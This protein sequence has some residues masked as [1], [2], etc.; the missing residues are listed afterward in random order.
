[1]DK[2][3]LGK[4]TLNPIT[5]LI[6][7]SLGLTATAVCAQEI[8][9]EIETMRLETITVIAQKR[10]QNMQ[11]VPVSVTAISGKQLTES[12][13][14]DMFDVT[15]SVPG[16]S[17]FQTQNAT[18]SSFSI[19][20]IGTGSQNFGLE[21]SVGLYVDGVYRARQNSMINNLVDVEAVEVLRGPQ[22]TLF[23]KNTPSGAIL[24]RTVAP[25][26][27]GANNFVEATIGNYGLV[28]YSA[29]ASISAIENILAFRVT[30]FGSQRDGIVSE[31]NSGDD[32]L[33]DR[34]RWG[35]RLQALYTPNDDISV[36]IIAD[37]SEINEICCAAPVQVSN[38]QAMAIEGK[39]GSDKLL[40][41][42]PFNATIFDG[43]DFFER[44]VAL[45]FL[46]ES[47]MKDSGLSAE[48]SWDINNQYTLISISALR[49]FDALDNID[50]DFTD[51]ELFGTQNDSQ[52]RSFSQELRLDYNGENINTIL[53]AY[54]FRQNLD[55]DY[56]L[57]TSEQFNQFFL[58][59]FSQGAF[60]GLLAGIDAL[61]AATGGLVAESSAPAPA[62]SAFDHRAQQKHESYAIFGQIDYHLSEKLTLT[63]GFRYTDE[64]KELSTIFSENLPGNIAFPTFFSSVG[65]PANPSSI[66]PGTLLYGAGVAGNVLAGVA[67]NTIDIT[68]P[69]G[70]LA[71]QTL[72]P[73]Q[74]LGWGFKP[75]GAITSDRSDINDTLNDDQLTGTLKLSY[76]SNRDTLLYASYGTGYKSGGTNTD[77]IAEGFDPIFA[78][79]TSR[80]LEVGIKTDFPAQD[81]RINAA[82]HSTTVDDFQANTFA[83]TGFNLQNAGDYK[84]S[85]FEVELI[86]LPTDTVEVNF[87]YARVNAE[88]DNFERGNCWIAY[89]WQTGISDPGQESLDPA[90]PNPFCN[91]SGGRPGGE[92]EDYT[93]IKVK[94]DF[95]IS[96]SVN[97][98]LVAEFSYTD[99]IVLDGSNDPLAVQD[100]YSLLNLRFFMN[101]DK[102]DMDLV[103]WGR[104]VLNEEY[105]KQI[106]FNTPLQEGKLNAYVA[107]P[108][109]FG[110]TI[111]KR[112]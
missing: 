40:S 30:A 8:E 92:P 112:F 11:D 17:A 72:V 58:S 105:I 41:Q 110:M 67:A 49:S 50:T 99:D 59:G 95:T 29:G 64:N 87:V 13:L 85:G 86:W 79:E 76:Q 111:R 69:E 101:F 33:N 56:S 39:F 83:G 71:L 109:T 23:G 91:R 93:M 108:A 16:L 4:F 22:G 94:K 24:V 19:R 38:M 35:L 63:A 68:T 75:L 32:V 2:I 62:F 77:R 14:K 106:N 5:V 42:T 37:Y 28:N 103:F 70:Q 55:L 31:V 9:E 74:S 47:I 12:V 20:G 107:N 15:A 44:K 82:A 96:E 66:V 84:A 54:Y 104:N 52:Q 3:I 45:S 89:T 6:T 10:K 27:Q 34:D 65:D 1:M 53:G 61:S 57:Y 7:L 36:R 90:A 60:N 100:S 21:S 80:A 97:T 81:L 18:N 46:P 26:H 43:D 48:I 73:F 78:A 98:Y 102:Y 51:A 88:Y 25:S